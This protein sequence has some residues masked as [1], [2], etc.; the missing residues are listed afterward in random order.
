MSFAAPTLCSIPPCSLSSAA[1][2]GTT[3]HGH[4][5][6]AWLVDQL[7]GQSKVSATA[8][9]R[10]DPNICCASKCC[11]QLT[12][13][14]FVQDIVVGE[15]CS[16]DR[17]NLEVTYPVV[18]GIIQ[19]WDDMRHIWDHTFFNLLTIDPTDCKILLTDPPL[20]PKSNR[21]KLLQT[22]FESYGFAAAFIQIQAVLTLY[23][24]GTHQPS[25]P[26]HPFVLICFTSNDKLSSCR[27]AIMHC[28]HVGA[29]TVFMRAE[30]HGGCRLTHWFGGGQ[31]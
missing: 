28:T 27:A 30:L 12:H 16:R 10:W 18:N 1:L 13:T 29:L 24:Q 20:N 26:D 15:Q 19:H 7:Y 6:L 11:N 8:S 21:E 22:M 3:F 25:A 9:S 17:L 5:S 4:R 14:S 23:A 2:L 31:W